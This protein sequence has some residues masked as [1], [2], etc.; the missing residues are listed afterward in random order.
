MTWVVNDIEP[1]IQKFSEER[2]RN[3]VKRPKAGRGHIWIQKLARRK[4][5]FKW[6]IS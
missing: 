3:T 1:N 6:S 2:R 5:G 4:N